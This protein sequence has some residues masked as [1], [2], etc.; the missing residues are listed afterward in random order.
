[1][2]IKVKHLKDTKTS[3]FYSWDVNE[4]DLEKIV[5]ELNLNVEDCWNNGIDEDEHFFYSNE[6]ES[7]IAEM[8]VGL[9]FCP[10]KIQEIESLI[11]KLNHKILN[12]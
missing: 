3:I 12:F 8:G 7:I 4:F 6:D 9:L 2:E 1:M 11:Y 10:N 5:S